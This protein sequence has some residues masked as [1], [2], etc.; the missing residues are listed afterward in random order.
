MLVVCKEIYDNMDK[1]TPNNIQQ[2]LQIG[3][4]WSD[5]T[6]A[7]TWEK[8]TRPCQNCFKNL[9]KLR[10]SNSMQCGNF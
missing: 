5:L 8:F 3:R 9:L 7:I 10:P 4:N 2:L 1:D 6:E